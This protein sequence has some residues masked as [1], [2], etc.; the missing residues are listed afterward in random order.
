MSYS[1]TSS[2]HTWNVFT[3]NS[4]NGNSVISVSGAT[5]SSGDLISVV[6]LP[7]FRLP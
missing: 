5:P 6:S 4:T 1:G 7:P 3:G 2:L